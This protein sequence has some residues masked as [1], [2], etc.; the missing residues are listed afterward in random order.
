MAVAVYVAVVGPLIV[1]VHVHGNVPVIDQ[2]HGS[3]PVHVNGHDQG[4]GHVHVPVYVNG[5]GPVGCRSYCGTFCGVSV[6]APQALPIKV[7]T[8][9]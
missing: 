2:V 1:A 4:S 7:S 9:R 6:K 3:V 8:T 5:H